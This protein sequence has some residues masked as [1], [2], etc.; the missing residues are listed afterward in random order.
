MNSESPYACWA[1]SSPGHKQGVDLGLVPD[2]HRGQEMKPHRQCPWIK[3]VCLHHRG[4]I[5]ALHCFVSHPW[6]CLWGGHWGAQYKV[7]LH[8][9][10]TWMEE[11]DYVPVAA[12]HL[13]EHLVTQPLHLFNL[14]QNSSKNTLTI[15][16]P[17]WPVLNSLS[18]SGLEGEN[19]KARYRAGRKHG[20]IENGKHS[21]ENYIDS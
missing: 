6:Y 13:V 17:Q 18:L 11:R 14:Y 12:N 8:I 3:W 4:N 5:A 9:G 19:F 10:I 15:Q 1:G 20:S 7:G 16:T 2:P 21:P